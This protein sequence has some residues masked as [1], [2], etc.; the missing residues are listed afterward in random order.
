[1]ILVN[2]ALKIQEMQV[3]SNQVFTINLARNERK[4]LAAFMEVPADG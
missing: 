4:L 1:M 2:L 3:T